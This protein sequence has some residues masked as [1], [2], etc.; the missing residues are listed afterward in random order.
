[1]RAYYVSDEDNENAI[2]VVAD[3]SREAKKLGWSSI[4]ECGCEYV[5]MR[6]HWLKKANMSNLKKGVLKSHLDALKRGF[7]DYI[8]YEDCPKCK[9]K[10]TTVYYDNGELGGFSCDECEDE[11][12]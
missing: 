11:N 7:F 3:N 5:D 8:K 2:A 4:R 9:T 1:M 6:V 10:N 12:S